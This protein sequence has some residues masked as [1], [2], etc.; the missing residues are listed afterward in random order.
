MSSD[1]NTP[2]TGQGDDEMSIFRPPIVR[3]AGATLN[4][5]LFA[6]TVDISAARVNN[7]R[8]IARF[9]K[10]LE[11]EKDIL[12]ADRLPSVKDDPDDTLAAQGRKCLLLRP[13]IK[14]DGQSHS[15]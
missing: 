2:M 10:Q 1:T 8:N 4:R 6:K 13:G 9:R 7:P 14:P 3:N 5:A 15:L 11:K 12:L